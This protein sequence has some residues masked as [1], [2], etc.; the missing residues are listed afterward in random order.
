[1]N[2]C[3]SC[4]A[5]T[6]TL[7]STWRALSASASS[8]EFRRSLAI[9]I[10]QSQYTSQMKS[11]TFCAARPSSNLS[12]LAVTSATRVFRRDITHLSAMVSEAGRP[13]SKPSGR[14]ISTKR[15]R[16]STA[17]WQSCGWP[18]PSRPKSACRCRVWSLP[19]ASGAARLRTIV[20]DDLQRVDAVAKAFGHLAPL[21]V[22]HK[23]VDEHGAERGLSGVGEA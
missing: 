1:M 21:R 11:C 6:S 22:A 16:H 7:T 23:A 2:G 19:P 9:S 17:C 13:S 14:F 12:R 3:R 5:C 18:S 4:S 15:A 20:A 10:Y 8:C